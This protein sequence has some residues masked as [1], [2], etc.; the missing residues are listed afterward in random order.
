M[1]VLSILTL[2]T[3]Q[4]EI[5]FCHWVEMKTNQGKPGLYLGFQSIQDRYLEKSHNSFFLQVFTLMGT[6][7]TSGQKN[8]SHTLRIVC[9]AL[10]S[11]FFFISLLS[12]P[13]ISKVVMQMQSLNV[14]GL[15]YD[16]LI[17]ALCPVILFCDDICPRQFCVNLTQASVFGKEETSVE[18]TPP[19]DPAVRHLHNQLLIWGEGR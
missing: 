11:N 14:A 5:S 18:R 4:Y 8:L 16:Q 6:V 17:S 9:V 2:P 10:R 13:K 1:A 12:N 19:L 15:P 7:G 3:H